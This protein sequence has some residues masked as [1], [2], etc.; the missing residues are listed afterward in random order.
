MNIALAIANCGTS[1]SIGNLL[2]GNRP[3]ISLI[4]RT[5]PVI[6]GVSSVSFGINTLMITGETRT[7]A[8]FLGS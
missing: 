7:S 5:S 1:F 6:D 4:D 8:I 3:I 2:G